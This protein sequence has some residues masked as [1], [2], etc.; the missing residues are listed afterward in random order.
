MATHPLEAYLKHMLQIRAV[1]EAF[2]PR[3]QCIGR[4][5][6]SGSGPD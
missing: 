3:V 1:G 5:Q 6:G 2:K 4:E